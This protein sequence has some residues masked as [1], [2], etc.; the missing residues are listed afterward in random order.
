MDIKW[1]VCLCFCTC[2]VSSTSGCGWSNRSNT[3]ISFSSD[4][5]FWAAFLNSF[6]A[7]AVVPS[8]IELLCVIWGCGGCVLMVVVVIAWARCRRGLQLRS[9]ELVY[10]FRGVDCCLTLPSY[11]IC[12]LGVVVVV[13]GDG[14]VALLAALPPTRTFQ[15]I[16]LSHFFTFSYRI[17]SC[18]LIPTPLNCLNHILNH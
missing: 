8:F 3:C 15:S 17:P 11:T 16:R 10:C 5:C 12:F 9:Y 18:N 14:A 13:L 6:F 7:E 2:L 4:F 1:V